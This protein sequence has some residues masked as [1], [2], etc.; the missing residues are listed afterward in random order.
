M[1]EWEPWSKAFGKV[2]GLVCSFELQLN[3]VLIWTPSSST[4]S[5]CAI[6]SFELHTSKSGKIVEKIRF[7]T[8]FTKTSKNKIFTSKDLE[9]LC[10]SSNNLDDLKF[11]RLTGFCGNKVLVNEEIFLYP[12]VLNDGARFCSFEP[13]RPRDYVVRRWGKRG[14]VIICEERFRPSFV[15]S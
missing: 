7:Y 6:Q 8:F 12:W 15:P 10:S 1:G 14:A 5:L 13:C 2:W 9:S 3:F 11:Q 4:Y